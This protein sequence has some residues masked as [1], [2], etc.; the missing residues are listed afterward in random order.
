L[1][2]AVGPKRIKTGIGLEL[3]GAKPEFD[4]LGKNLPRRKGN[5]LAV[6]IFDIGVFQ[7]GKLV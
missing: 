3:L 4:F 6:V 7:H 2:E 1:P 5:Y